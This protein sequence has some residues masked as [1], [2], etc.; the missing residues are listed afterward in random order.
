MTFQAVH[1]LDTLKTV[2]IDLVA[3]LV[4]RT[5]FRGLTGSRAKAELFNAFV[6]FRT[7]RGI[8][9][10]HAGMDDFVADQI[11]RTVKFRAGQLG[12]DLFFAA[13]SFVTMGIL[14]TL[15]ALA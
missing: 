5:V 10:F 4:Q 6:E 2:S 7:I 11:V 15:N 3:N 8:Q 14:E 1:I 12:A 13:E 9:A